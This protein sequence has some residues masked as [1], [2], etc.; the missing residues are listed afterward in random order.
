MSCC[1]PGTA[2]LLA[3]MA[4]GVADDLAST[5]LLATDK[6]VVAHRR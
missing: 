1:L 5:L 2:D 6:P 3:K 4:H